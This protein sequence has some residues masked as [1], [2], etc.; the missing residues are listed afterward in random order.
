MTKCALL[1]TVAA[2]LLLRNPILGAKL[3]KR[4]S[5]D[6]TVLPSACV[7]ILSSTTVDAA[8]ADPTNFVDNYCGDTCGEPLYNYFKDCDAGS[9]NATVFDFYC[10]SNAAGEQ[11]LPLTLSAVTAQDSVF[12]EC[13]E[14][15]QKNW[16]VTAPVKVL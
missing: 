14:P 2:C 11:C 3:S 8:F 9:N 7:R 15:I 13:A 6:I 16:P 1:V 5:C 10:S 4:Q 12:Y